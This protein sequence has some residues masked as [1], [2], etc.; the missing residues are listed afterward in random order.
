VAVGRVGGG[1]RRLDAVSSS[2]GWENDNDKK[3]RILPNKKLGFSH[4]PLKLVEKQ[5]SLVP[6][7]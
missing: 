2:I 4:Q 1:A 3:K 5:V 7:G 6:E